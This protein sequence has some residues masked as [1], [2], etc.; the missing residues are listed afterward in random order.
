MKNINC[1]VW[2]VTLKCNARCIHCGSSAGCKK[3]DEMSTQQ[4]LNV[5]KQMNEANIKNVNLIGG[6]LFLRKDW[7]EIVKT[8]HSY[9]I[10]ISIVTNG[11]CLN[12]ENL[13][14]LASEGVKTIGISID[15]GKAETHDYIRQVP[16]L[17]DRI[18]K[19][20]E[21]NETPIQ[22][23]AITTLNKLNFR[24]IPILV[25]KLRKSKFKVWEVQTASPHGRM[26]KKMALSRLEHY[27][28]GI[29]IEQA[30][31]TLPK[32]D[33]AIVG[34][35]DFGYYSSFLPRVSICHLWQGCPAG[36][37]SLGIKYNGATDNNQVTAFDGEDN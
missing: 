23:T 4:M 29:L 18:F 37:C 1:C 20:V 31:Q 24:E 15:G 11:I 25:E 14:F 33:I 10:N 13:E 5:C 7:K 8:L 16:G 17:F 21:E 32:E 2:E 22:F 28:S 3:N 34:N 6:E 27:F 12:K 9:N 36:I 35:H 26:A 30:R 19:V